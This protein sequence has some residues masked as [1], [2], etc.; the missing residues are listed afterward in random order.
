MWSVV[1]LGL[2]PTIVA[3]WRIVD[4]AGDYGYG[5]MSVV[6]LS[7]SPPLVYLEMES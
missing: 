7:N 2:S 3:R 5:S 4:H 1:A 6:A